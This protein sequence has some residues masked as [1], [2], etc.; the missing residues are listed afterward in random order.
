[1]GT[2]VGCGDNLTGTTVY[3]NPASNYFNLR[4]ESQFEEKG[5]W[6]LTNTAGTV[7]S[8]NNV[9]VYKGQNLNQ[10]KVS[11]LAPGIYILQLSSANLQINKQVVVV[12]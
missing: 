12:H 2:T 4:F 8:K 1:M 6:K 3:P 10:I 5:N 9:Q 7:V 11:D